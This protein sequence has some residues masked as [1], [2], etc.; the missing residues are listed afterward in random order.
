MQTVLYSPSLVLWGG[1]F[2]ISRES[3]VDKIVQ[4][5]FH[6]LAYLSVTPEP[7][8]SVFNLQSF[9]QFSSPPQTKYSSDLRNHPVDTSIS[10]N[11]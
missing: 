7:T 3:L 11:D 4:I 2:G 10:K 8:K 1:G 9:T 5:H 6:S